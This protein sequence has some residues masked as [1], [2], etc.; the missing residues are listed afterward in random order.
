MKVVVPF[1]GQVFRF[2]QQGVQFDLL[3]RRR[4]PVLK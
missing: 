4:F 3:G 2:V 1:F